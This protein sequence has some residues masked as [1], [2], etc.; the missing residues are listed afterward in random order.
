MDLVGPMQTSSLS[1]K[2][3]LLLVIDDYSRFTWVLL[4][5]IKVKYLM[6]L[7]NY[8]REFK[9]KKGALITSIRSDR[10]GEFVNKDF[11]SFY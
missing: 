8:A 1:G 10:G 7:R 11:V 4:L 9:N 3:Y 2:K 6:H 5:I